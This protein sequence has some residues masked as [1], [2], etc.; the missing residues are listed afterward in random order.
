VKPFFRDKSGIFPLKIRKLK[1]GKEG[2]KEVKEIL[3]KAQ[4]RQ[5]RKAAID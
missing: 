5:G 4:G 3:K 2:R 1:V